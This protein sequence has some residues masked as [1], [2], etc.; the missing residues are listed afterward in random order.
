MFVLIWKACFSVDP[1]ENESSSS[2]DAAATKDRTLGW[3]ENGSTAGSTSD[4]S[5]ANSLEGRKSSRG[6]IFYGLSWFT[7]VNIEILTVYVTVGRRGTLVPL[8]SFP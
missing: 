4:L 8:K 2:E 5:S 6:Y 1:E 7:L 3:S